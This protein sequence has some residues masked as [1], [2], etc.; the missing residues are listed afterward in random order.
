MILVILLILNVLIGVG[1]ALL[2]RRFRLGRRRDRGVVAGCGH[3]GR[4]ES[5]R[6]ELLLDAFDLSL[7]RHEFFL[8]NFRLRGVHRRRV[9]TTALGE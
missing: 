9:T 8:Q 1:G 5:A 7:G 2:R 4:V 6:C 3:L